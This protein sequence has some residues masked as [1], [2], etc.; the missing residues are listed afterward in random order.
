MKGI[1]G[2]CLFNELPYSNV[3]I[4][5]VHGQF[6]NS[7]TCDLPTK[8]YLDKLRSLYEMD[9]FSLNAQSN[10]NPD[11]NLE[12]QHIR[13][14]YFS[15]YNFSMLKD[16]LTRTENKISFSMLHNNVRSLRRNLENFHT[17]LLDE[18]DHDFSVIGVTETK[19]TNMTKLDF[20][21]QIPNYQFE[22]VPTPLS[23]G[24][25][26]MYVSNSLNYTILEKTSNEAF[27]ALWIEIDFLHC[28]NIICGVIYRQHNS[29]E[30]FQTAFL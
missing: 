9:L 14:K 2:K 13:S 25:V 16:T 24:G 29:P 18:L 3:D 8:K 22:Y 4:I 30:Q 1:A 15:P 26:G 7:L 10:L 21:P 19:I 5:R 23:C 11:R 20:N 28:K 27:Q 12:N 6:N 17:H